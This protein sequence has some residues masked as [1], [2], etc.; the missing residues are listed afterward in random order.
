MKDIFIDNNIAKDFATP[1]NPYYKPLIKWLFDYNKNEDD[2]FLVLSKKL[3]N[4]YVAS[5]QSCI[6]STNIVLI[7]DKLT[8]EGRINRFSN[9]DI[10][11]FMTSTYKP[12]VLRDLRSSYK[13]RFHIPI[14]LLSDRKMALTKD[15][16]L[17]F[18]LEH[19]PKH[20]VTVADCPSKVDYQ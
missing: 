1:I 7:V 20:S 3:M 6:K 19:F 11:Q 4:E 12:K 9:N 13:D 14:I 10:K 5:A 18:D 2:A 8:R 15:V 16:N 17:G